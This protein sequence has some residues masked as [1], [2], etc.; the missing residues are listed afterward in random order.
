VLY[1]FFLRGKGREGRQ[2]SPL[3][4]G[5][6]DAEVPAEVLQKTDKPSKT[7]TVVL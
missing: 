5:E 1:C 7:G 2:E 4:D 6:A 3:K